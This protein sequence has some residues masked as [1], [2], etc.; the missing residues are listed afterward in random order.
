MGARA[1][2]YVLPYGILGAQRR[3]TLPRSNAVRVPAIRH[4]M[5]L[6][7]EEFA[8]VVPKSFRTV[9]RWEHAETEPDELAVL[10]LREL[11][12]V[13]ALAERVLAPGRVGAWLKTPNGSLGGVAPY[14]VLRTPGGVQRVK[15]VLTA[16]EW[17][18]PG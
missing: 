3:T 9:F 10:R 14:Q 16:L 13:L 12:D 18:I 1:L 6:S 11:A 5:G 4:R 7:L 8:H 15:D 17:G 2:T